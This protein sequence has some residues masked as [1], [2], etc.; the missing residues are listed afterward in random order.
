MYRSFGSI[1]HSQICWKVKTE[2][3]QLLEIS[4]LFFS[5]LSGYMFRQGSSTLVFLLPPFFLVND[6]YAIAARY[7][8][9]I[10]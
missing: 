1:R 5:F 8:A 10:I 6:E 2:E 7:E 9:D 3:I 4:F